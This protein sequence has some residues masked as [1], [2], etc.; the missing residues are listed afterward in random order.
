MMDNLNLRQLKEQVETYA[1]VLSNLSRSEVELLLTKYFTIIDM[2]EY[3]KTMAH[4]LMSATD[5]VD[6]VPGI[7]SH[8]KQIVSDGIFFFLIHI[9]TER[10]I[11]LIVDQLFL[12]KDCSS[13][14]RLV[15][16]AKKIPT[17]HKLGQ[18]IAR[19]RN[20][21]ERFRKWLISLENGLQE[22]D[23]Q[24]IRERIEKTLGKVKEKYDIHIETTILS[25]A[26]VGIVIPFSWQDPDTGRRRQ[27]VFKVLKPHVRKYLDEELSL[28][29]KLALFYDRNRQKYPIKDF[30]FIETFK[31]VA[32]ALKKEIDL[33]GEQ[34]NL[35]RAVQFYAHDKRITI[36]SP[37][38]LSTSEFTAME[39]IEGDKVT[40]ILLNEYE[41]RV[42]TRI[43]FQSLIVYPLFSYEQW[44]P[45]HG[46]PHGGNLFAYKGHQSS[47]VTIALLDWSQAGLLSRQ[48]RYGILQLLV[49]I[50]MEDEEH[51]YRTIKALSED[52]FEDFPETA[53]KVRDTIH[54]ILKGEEVHRFQHVERVFTLV[55]RIALRGVKFAR[56]LLLFRKAIFTLKSVLYELDQN[57][58][59][60]SYMIEAL[61]NL[62][63][64]E[65]PQRGV[66][67]MFP[68][69]ERSN[70]YKTMLTNGDLLC[71]WSHLFLRMMQ[72]GFFMQSE[73]TEFNIE[74][75]LKLLFSNLS[76]SCKCMTETK[77]FFPNREKITGK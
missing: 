11:S 68:L 14:E 47:E 51:L 71:L 17:L 38:P 57:L 41:K 49:G 42:C 48:Q 25:E 12:K 73:L 54:D 20:V 1:G 62:L 69:W 18:V 74:L 56:D 19:N 30:T 72:K 13:E 9:N 6:V 24:I 35:K 44:T 7:Y 52:N 23:C 53:K 36:P 15:E 29:A 75:M 43:L 16:L 45:F 77:L 22:T 27:G 39:F 40:D 2:S 28:L 66:N 26:S 37:L 58:N 70:Q 10:F 34:D 3:R 76:Q 65:V 60:D 46:D 21:D 63:I 32:A 64:D 8:F 50:I 31:D 4:M 67:M 5:I 59:M 33:R 61:G 55:D